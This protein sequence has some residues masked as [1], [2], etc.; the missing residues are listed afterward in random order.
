MESFLH[1]YLHI[2]FVLFS[3]CS[4]SSKEQYRMKKILKA[5]KKSSDN[6]SLKTGNNNGTSSGA[7]SKSPSMHHLPTPTAAANGPR[8]ASASEL[9]T[10]ASANAARS[11]VSPSLMDLKALMLD[12]ANPPAETPFAFRQQDY[13]FGLKL[14]SGTYG[15]ACE[16]KHIP[17]GDI[18]A[19]KRIEK[20]M[21]RGREAR[22]KNE[23][24]ILL[25][26]KHPNL[27]SLLDW[28]I[29]AQHIFLVTELYVF[30]QVMIY[31]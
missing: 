8:S 20:R 10:L 7:S 21:V 16:A 24:D 14:G 15:V 2:R 17:T 23:I 3:R 19:V 25:R 30:I 31:G 5:F 4:L 9:S 27:L 18:V 13:Q 28:G 11:P 6:L 1:L 29:S 26:A 12:G 22:L